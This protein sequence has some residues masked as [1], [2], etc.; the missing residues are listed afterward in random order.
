MFP[1]RLLC[2]QAYQD[3]LQAIVYRNLDRTAA[4]DRFVK[5]PVLIKC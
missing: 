3:C 5:F 4:R 2:R 1:N